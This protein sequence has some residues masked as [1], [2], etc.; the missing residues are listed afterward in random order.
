VSLTLLQLFW[1]C[2]CG[3]CGPLFNVDCALNWPLVGTM[4]F[5]VCLDSLKPA[6]PAPQ[7]P[8]ESGFVDRQRQ[9]NRRATFHIRDDETTNGAG[10][11]TNLRLQLTRFSSSMAKRF[12]REDQNVL[13]YQNVTQCAPDSLFIDALHHQWSGEYETLEAKHGWVQ[14]LF[15]T[16][17]SS[18]SAMGSW[19]SYPLTKR[20]AARIRRDPDAQWRFLR[21]F[22]L[23]LAFLGMRLV[24][25]RTGRLTR[26]DDYVER[27]A[28]IRCNP[29]NLQR[30]TRV[31]V[32]LGQLGF[33]RYRAPLLAQ[34]SHEVG[35]GLLGEHKA[36]VSLAEYWE[37]LV[38]EVDSEWYAA[39]TLESGPEDREEGCLFAEDGPLARKRRH[40]SRW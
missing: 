39:E 38:H 26:T 33:G 24:D 11:L 36:K 28:N 12:A 14:W 27:L 6:P 15:P 30:I 3:A 16:Y 8:A 29:H 40:T 31:L 21:S 35:E 23:M 13:F 25:Q 9:R 7:P 2:D 1:F 5:E 17:S 4:C 19:R 20:G 18:A 32:S 37:P 10:G 34:L 22:E